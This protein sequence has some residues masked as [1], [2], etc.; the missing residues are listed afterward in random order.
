MIAPARR[1]SAAATLIA[2]T[3]VGLLARL[4]TTGSGWFYWD[5]LTL[6]AQAR[7]AGT[8]AQLLGRI[9]DGHFMPGG[10]VLEWVLAHTAWLNW[11]VAVGLVGI[12]HA[13][14]LAA[15]ATAVWIV[16]PAD[17]RTPLVV[18]VPMA[19]YALSPI[20]IPATA[21]IAAAI[22]ALPLHAAM[23][24]ASALLVRGFRTAAAAESAPVRAAGA[25][26]GRAAGGGPGIR[27]ARRDG[28]LA[29]AVVLAGLLFSE[30]ALAI[31]PAAV[32]LLGALHLAAPDRSHRDGH[33]HRDDRAGA[34]P[35]R[36]RLAWL[37]GPASVLSICWAVMY[38]KLNTH[39]EIAPVEPS[40]SAFIEA[41]R[42]TYRDVLLPAAAGGPW[43]WDR[44]HP[45]PPF[46]TP[47]Q[48]AWLLGAA[49]AAAVLA[50]TL[51]RRGRA[52]WLWAVPAAY[53]VA[54]VAAL[55]VARL[56]P[57]AAG[58][59]AGTMRHVSE[60]AV[61]AALAAALV[62]SARPQRVA[63]APTRDGAVARRGLSP[64]AAVI[65]A[66]MLVASSAVTN[67]LFARSWAAQPSRTYFANLRAAAETMGPGETLL[68][69]DVAL[70]VL[71]PVVH[72][73]NT[74]SRLVG[75]VDGYPQIAPYARTPLL[76]DAHGV[77]RPAEVLELRRTVDGP[78]PGC[79]TP[80]GDTA[81]AAVRIALD[82]PLIENLWTVQFGYL[83]TGAG[84]AQIS[85]GDGPA[86]LVPLEEGLAQLT[87]QLVGEGEE[88]R[89]AVSPE[90]GKVCLGAARIGG[91]APAP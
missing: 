53:P 51:A 37:L 31:V 2:L 86:Q 3:V 28:L 61:L 24:I 14:A 6:G 65:C 44:W 20:A 4:M 30:R 41:L 18:G 56:S 69:Q 79:G 23:A 55:T 32:L 83:A 60:V 73:D 43:T 72:P 64:V 15:V 27:A 81:P 12:L 9:H 36:V 85:I 63:A 75:G 34:G 77:P 16:V 38:G 67:G 71:L 57:E 25:P 49:V 39:D 50:Y 59:I 42:L 58:A 26:G 17:R 54:P 68:D 78:E 22:T 74:L 48:L 13:V 29:A 33:D 70:D 90:A 46:A 7:A 87:V 80:A 45:G 21:W 91:L 5:D 52:A 10:W 40:W 88:L 35:G 76:V 66:L 89:I 1:R 84:T 62:L 47:P 8:P 82:G 11:P 19:L